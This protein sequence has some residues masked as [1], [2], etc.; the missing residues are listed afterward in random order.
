MGRVPKKRKENLDKVLTLAQLYEILDSEWLG[1]LLIGVP[2]EE[3]VL[4]R[5][6]QEFK[7]RAV[8]P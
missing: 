8:K 3:Y 7:E 6:R 1:Y 5:L 2:D 4:Q